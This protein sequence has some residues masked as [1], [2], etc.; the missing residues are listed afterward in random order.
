MWNLRAAAHVPA[1]VNAFP[2]ILYFYAFMWVWHLSLLC[3]W[4]KALSLFLIANEIETAFSLYL[5]WRSCMDVNGID[6]DCVL[7]ERVCDRIWILNF[8]DVTFTLT[9]WQRVGRSVNGFAFAVCFFSSFCFALFIC[10]RCVFQFTRFIFI[11][12]VSHLIVLFVVRSFYFIL[13][14]L[15]VIATVT[16][17]SQ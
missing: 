10:F 16:S 5:S 17:S 3:F 9:Q 8:L 2:S 11:P 12:S 6:V 13:F 4:Q 14:S 1:F 7:A 15:H